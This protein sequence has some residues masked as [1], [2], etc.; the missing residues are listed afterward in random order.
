MRKLFWIITLHITALFSAGVVATDKETITAGWYHWD[1][2]QYLDENRQLT[3]L[4]YALVKAIF[5]ASSIEVDYDPDSLDSWNKNQQDVLSGEKDVAAGAFTSEHR[6]K[7]YHLSKPYRYEWNTL[8]VRSNMLEDFDVYLIEDLIELIK[9]KQFRLGVIKGYNYTSNE[10]NQFVA[11]ETA[12]GSP[13]IVAA[14]TEEENFENIVSG[15]ADIVVSDRLVG[16]RILWKK[17]LGG[18]ISEHQLKLPAK[19]IH[20]LIHRSKDPAK[21]ARSMRLLS[22]FNQGVDQLTADGGINAIIGNYL[23]PVLMNITVQRDWFY[24]VDIVGALFFALAGLLIA[25]DNKYD[26]FGTL[27]MTGLL[28]TGGG[29]MR[30]LIV[31]RYPVVL[32]IPDYIYIIVLVCSIG[33]LLCFLHEYMMSKLPSYRASVQRHHKHFLFSRE[34]IEAIALGAYTIVGVGVAVEMKLAPLWL[35]GPL[36]G[37]LTSCGG[38]IIANA[39]RTG[40]VKNMRGGVEP[41]CALFWGTFFSLFMMWQADRLDPKEVFIGV[42]IT[43]AGCTITMLMTSR[44][45]L[46]SPCMTINTFDTEDSDNDT[47]DTMTSNQDTANE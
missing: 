28:V 41:E 9:Q 34:L 29:L 10:L 30:D 22:A 27:V 37:C 39:L 12:K 4:D 5:N 3:G 32:K 13:H 26:I 40:E 36:L 47:P 7:V 6:K 38:G 33:F 11:D 1:P 42:M 15:K 19:P 25:R 35:W 14:T 2:Y 16:A 21:D 24:I 18:V 43:L 31:G 45:R 8:Y 44:Y 23:F 20:L 46:E 17:K